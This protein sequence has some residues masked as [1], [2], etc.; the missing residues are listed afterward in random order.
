[1]LFTLTAVVTLEALANRQGGPRHSEALALGQGGARLTSRLVSRTR[2][3]R[4][5]M[6]LEGEPSMSPNLNVLGTELECCC[7]DVRGTGIG[8]GFYRNGFCSTGPNDA[9]RHTVCVQATAEFLAFSKAVGNDLSQPMPEYMFPGVNPGDRWC[10]CASRWKQALDAGKAPRLF[11]ESTHEKTLQHAP[12]DVLMEYAVDREK[13]ER[14]VRALDD[15]RQQLARSV[16]LDAG[17]AGSGAE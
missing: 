2:R 8:T 12:L 4:P 5:S 3:C 11:L 13:A 14:A 9:G 15:L 6:T 7:A 10:L 1:M 16:N 17:S